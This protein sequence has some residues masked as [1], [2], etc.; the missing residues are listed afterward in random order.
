MNSIVG[1]STQHWR[2]WCLWLRCTQ[3]HGMEEGFFLK[4]TFFFS[5]HSLLL[6]ISHAHARTH[7]RL[8]FLPSSTAMTGYVAP[9]GADQETCSPPGGERHTQRAGRAN[10]VTLVP[11][12]I[13]RPTKTARTCATDEGLRHR[14][15]AGLDS[16]VDS[17]TAGDPPSHTHTHPA[18]PPHK[19][20]LARYHIH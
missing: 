2:R 20:T 19:D 14:L 13:L 4:N 18:P 9:Y 11:R 6:R 3:T 12:N 7:A 10:S 15:H 1:L 17:V 5:A 16:S 8:S